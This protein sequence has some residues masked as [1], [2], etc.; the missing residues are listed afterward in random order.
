LKAAGPSHEEG[1]SERGSS[2]G[3]VSQSVSTGLRNVTT[4]SLCGRTILVV[5]DEPLVALDVAETIKGAGASVLLT[6]TLKDGLRLAEQADVSA[7]VVDFGLIDGEASELC[8]RLN[9]RGVPYSGYGHVDEACRGGLVLP[10]PATP[11]A[12]IYALSKALTRGGERCQA[13]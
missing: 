5:E 7:A 12:L 6:H 13:D 10:K 11:G 9:G 4:V 1:R 3:L 2:S 8:Q